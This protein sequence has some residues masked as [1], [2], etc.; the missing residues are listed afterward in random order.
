MLG[1]CGAQNSNI[2]GHQTLQ[3]IPLELT[4]HLG[5][6]QEFVDGDEIQFLLSLGSDA[7]IYMYYVDADNNI[8]QIL[9]NENQS[10][11]FYQHGFFLTV[12]EYDDAY[13]FIISEPFGSESIWVLASDQKPLGSGSYTSMEE[14]RNVIKGNSKKAYN[15]YE[16]KIITR[17]K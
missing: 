12:P 9:P 14:I 13:R 10:S 2:S 6:K 8:S 15:E 16:L 4:T 17:K 7:Y 1:A 5:D 3:S 11:N